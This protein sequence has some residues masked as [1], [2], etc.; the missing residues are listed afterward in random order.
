VC[1]CCVHMLQEQP[2]VWITA[3]RDTTRTLAKLMESPKGCR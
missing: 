1:D 2:P 3:I